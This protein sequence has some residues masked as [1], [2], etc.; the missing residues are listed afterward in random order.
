LSKIFANDYNDPRFLAT[1]TVPTG[2]AVAV[3]QE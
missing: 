1:E 2:A 3:P